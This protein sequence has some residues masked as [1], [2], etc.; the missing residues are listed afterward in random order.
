MTTQADLR[1]LRLAPA[2]ATTHHAT[3]PGSGTASKPA[4]RVLPK[5]ADKAAYQ[6]GVFIEVTDIA[7]LQ[8]ALAD[9]E[10]NDVQRVFENLK[11]GSQ[12]HLAAFTARLDELRD[13]DQNGVADAGDIDALFAAFQSGS[14]DFDLD[15]DGMVNEA[16]VRVLVED[17]FATSLGDANLDGSV[18][19]ADFLVL[20][21][22]FGGADVGWASG[23]F[24]GDSTVDFDDFLVLSGNFDD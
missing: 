9:V 12:N 21:G 3:G 15:G 10:H 20:S 16:D 18:T 23:D 14:V 13:L 24:D 4:S 5:L 6:V 1:R 19:F 11:S 8:A 7:D 22:N 17:A 2:R